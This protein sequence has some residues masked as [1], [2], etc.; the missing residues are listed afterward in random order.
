MV[1][2]PQCHIGLGECHE[3]NAGILGLR[4]RLVLS[5]PMGCY[6]DSCWRS[7]VLLA[8][9]GEGANMVPSPFQLSITE[10]LQNFTIFYKIL[11]D[12]RL[13]TC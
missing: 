12:T 7:G 8:L 3:K 13:G 10:L 2:I 11:V 6:R 1:G 5:E 9:A 4:R